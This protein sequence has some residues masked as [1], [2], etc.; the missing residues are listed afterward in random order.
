MKILLFSLSLFFC[1]SWLWAAPPVRIDG[2]DKIDTVDDVTVT[3][4]ATLVK[5][6][7]ASRISLNC[8]NT[9][10]TVAVRWGDANV[11]AGSGQ[12]I[13]VNAS[14]AIQNIGAVYM[15][16]EGANVT[17]TCTEETQ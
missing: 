15:I 13:P 3:N 8:T 2:G 12:R 5:A 14:I 1:A 16:S 10:G 6:A 4:S 7:N 9:S 11:T 17:V